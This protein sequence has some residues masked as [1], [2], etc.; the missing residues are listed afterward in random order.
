MATSEN[1]D[2]LE[3]AVELQ[4]KPKLIDPPASFRSAVWKNFGFPQV[5]GKVDKS[6]SVCKICFA[7]VSYKT[8]T[9]SNMNNSQKR[10]HSIHTVEETKVTKKVDTK[11]SYLY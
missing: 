3:V 4:G 5:D 11:Q 8:G 9:T 10:K 6:K 2:E 1:V 7:S